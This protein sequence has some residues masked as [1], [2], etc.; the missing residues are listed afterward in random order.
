MAY[1]VSYHKGQ[2]STMEDFWTVDQYLHKLKD[3]P[4]EHFNEKENGPTNEEI[5][6]RP[7]KRAKNTIELEFD[8]KDS[9][10]ENKP[11]DIS[12]CQFLFYFAI[13]DGH[14]GTEAAQFL[15]SHFF[16][17]IVHKFKQ[18]ENI[19]E[20]LRQ[21]FEEL[22]KEF[23]ERIEEKDLDGLV[24]STATAVVI[25]GNQLFVANIGDSDAILYSKGGFKQ[26]TETHST[27]NVM[28]IERVVG[29]GGKIVHDKNKIARVGHPVWNPI[30]VNIA[31]TRS[32]GDA[33]FKDN[34]Y[35]T[36]EGKIM[37][38]GL[39]STPFFSKWTLT[40]DDYFIIIASDGLWD[41]MSF[42]DVA[43]F[44]R[45]RILTVDCQKICDE[46]VNL[47]TVAPAADNVTIIL[48]KLALPSLSEELE[49]KTTTT[50][51]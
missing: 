51:P 30:L 47:A 48:V 43:T 6:E 5:D 12:D 24:G 10:T 2:R 35:T 25:L 13:Y 9:K 46:L 41:F 32:I 28:E 37:N 27:Q 14:G 23:L 16:S 3:F 40:R 34:K 31:L 21:T 33:Y 11:A 19:E 50:L 15:K 49:G 8:I 45:S 42:E 4:R 36:K 22:E 18:Q 44:I 26:M 7:S 38:S 1:G 39:I 20:I 17:R 29:C